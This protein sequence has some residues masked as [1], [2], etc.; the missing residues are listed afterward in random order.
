MISKWL[1]GVPILSACFAIGGSVEGAPPGSEPLL[2]DDTQ[3][4]IREN[5]KLW[6]FRRALSPEPG[7]IVEGPLR[8]EA[9]DPDVLADA[10]EAV[11]NVLQPRLAGPGIEKLFV[12]LRVRE[13]TIPPCIMDIAVFRH[14]TEDGS[15][16]LLQDETLVAVVYRDAKPSEA[17]PDER[18]LQTAVGILR[19]PAGAAQQLIPSRVPAPLAVDRGLREFAVTGS[20]KVWWGFLRYAPREQALDSFDKNRPRDAWLGE[21]M[22]LTDGRAVCFMIRDTHNAPLGPRPR[23]APQRRFTKAPPPNRTPT[24]AAATRP[25]RR[26][27]ATPLWQGIVPP[28]EMDRE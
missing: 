20:K 23:F 26:N 13:K 12:L 14:D 16:F 27:Q 5:R 22:V 7:D 17:T 3:A 11:R 15:L 8:P 10:G 28:W 19:L 21:V 4:A 9:V 1:F 18:I 2:D 6:D 24:S 25:A